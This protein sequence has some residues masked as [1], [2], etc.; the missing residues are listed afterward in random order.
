MQKFSTRTVGRP[1]IPNTLLYLCIV[2]RTLGNQGKKPRKKTNQQNCERRDPNKL[3]SNPG[4]W[5]LSI[6]LLIMRRLIPFLLAAVMA[7]FPPSLLLVFIG[8]LASTVGPNSCTHHGAAGC[9]VAVDVGGFAGSSPTVV[10]RG[11]AHAVPHTAYVYPSHY[12]M[13]ATTASIIVASTMSGSGGKRSRSGRGNTGGLVQLVSADWTEQQTVHSGAGTPRQSSQPLQ[14]GQ[15]QPSSS[16]QQLEFSSLKEIANHHAELLAQERAS[17]ASS[18]SGNDL[19]SKEDK[20]V[21]EAPPDTLKV[22]VLGASRGKSPECTYSFVE[23]SNTV[24]FI[25]Y[26]YICGADIKDVGLEREHE[27][28]HLTKNMPE[29]CYL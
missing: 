18:S 28:V 26:Y 3:S 8:G 20:V 13:V 5:P 4:T 7:S 17:S 22:S 6:I 25:Y 23:F 19:N 29:G 10:T 1:L 27:T 2:L 16:S 24:S 9:G 11:V 14:Q 21:A 15:P 12:P